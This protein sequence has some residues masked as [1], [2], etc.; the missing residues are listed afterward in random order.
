MDLIDAGVYLCN[1]A[2]VLA[3]VCLS[4]IQAVVCLFPP[5]FC[6]TEL[7]EKVV[8]FIEISSLAVIH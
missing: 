2:I 7:K 4:V 8:A 3:G 1:S 5:C 6:Q